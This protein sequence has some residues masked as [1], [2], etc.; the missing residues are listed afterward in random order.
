[1]RREVA[2]QMERAGHSLA[3]AAGVLVAAADGTLRDER[4]AVLRALQA[5]EAAVLANQ[6]PS[7]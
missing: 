7:A 3:L 4:L 2:E 1:M 6:R 5:W